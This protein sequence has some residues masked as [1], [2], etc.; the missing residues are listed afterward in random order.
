MKKNSKQQKNEARIAAQ[1]IA[2]QITANMNPSP[3]AIMHR[4]TSL[5]AAAKKHGPEAFAFA[6]SQIEKA[7]RAYWTDR[8]HGSP[9]DHVPHHEPD[10]RRRPAW[11]G[12][13]RLCVAADR[14]RRPRILEASR[15]RVRRHHAPQDCRTLPPPRLRI[16]DHRRLAGACRR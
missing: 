4:I 11:P 7:A 16:L 3:K 8:Q 5:T 13:V 10:H 2:E 12:F 6:L 14:D 15:P 1:V 9:R